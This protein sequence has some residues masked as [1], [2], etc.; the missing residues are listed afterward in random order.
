MSGPT[1]WI[2]LRDLSRTGVPT[3]LERYARWHAETAGRSERGSLHV[4]A[5][6]GGPLHHRLAESVSS[7]TVLQAHDRSARWANAAV[8][9]ADTHFRSKVGRTAQR[10]VWAA[11]RP[12]ATPDLAVVHGL[13]GAA[14]ADLV[15]SGV[16]LVT[17][18][19]E[20]DMAAARALRPDALRSLL[21]SSTSVLAVSAA[22]ENFVKEL[23]PTPVEIVPGSVDSVDPNVP[24]VPWPED[25]TRAPPGSAVVAACGDPSFRKG[26]DRFVALAHEVRRRRPGTRFVW[27]GGRPTGGFAEPTGPVEWLEPSPQPWT[28]LGDVS[29]LV[30]PS[31]EDPLPLAAL[32]AGA[33]SIPVIATDCGGLTPLLGPLDAVVDGR[34]IEAFA[35]RVADVLTSR[36]RAARLAADF[37]RIVTR[38]YSTDVVGPRWWSALHRAARPTATN[39][40]RR[41]RSRP[42]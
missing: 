17:H 39:A 10:R 20:L 31:R 36:D 18:V 12:R 29:L 35:D 23:T 24:R 41:I 1:V 26:A 15:P 22:V 37:G 30:V 25:P 16:R 19:H 4:I 5:R 3:A 21:G 38:D 6:F 13:G 2:L 7:L 34:D 11:R 27:V 28:T 32:E 14:L 40:H 8:S 42:R 33:R 9:R